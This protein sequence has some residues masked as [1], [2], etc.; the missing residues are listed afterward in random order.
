MFL[1]SW[2]S[3]D[4]TRLE[5]S[6]RLGS[7]WSRQEEG[8]TCLRRCLQMHRREAA[9]RSRAR[10]ARILSKFNVESMNKGSEKGANSAGELSDGS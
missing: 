10:I 2:Y 1:T 4:L 3:R 9:T 5:G 8:Y 7:G 6:T